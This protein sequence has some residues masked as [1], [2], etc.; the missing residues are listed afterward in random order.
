[1]L[2][3]DIDVSA[4]LASEIE[5]VAQ[6]LVN[7]MNAAVRTQ[8]SPLQAK[9]TDVMSKEPPVWRKKRRWNSER[10]RIYVIAMLRKQKN[11]PYRRTHTLSKSWKSSLKATGAGGELKLENSKPSAQF[12]Q[13]N[14]AQLMHLD[15]GWPQI[16]THKKAFHDEARDIVVSCWHE[17]NGVKK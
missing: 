16:K 11:L 10:Q 9:M 8:L 2:G 7:K 3:I 17:V 1:M 13:G 5:D 4:Y 15:S 6:G 14:R 12:V